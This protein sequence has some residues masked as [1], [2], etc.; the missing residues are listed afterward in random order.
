MRNMP[1]P[2]CLPN[3]FANILFFSSGGRRFNCR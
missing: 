3:P 2:V 1:N